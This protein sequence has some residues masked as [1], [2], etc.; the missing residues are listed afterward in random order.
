M[1]KQRMTVGGLSVG[2]IGAVAAGNALEFYDFLIF[3][4]F[5]VQIGN[6][7]FPLQNENSRL[8]FALATFGVGF[9]FR[10]VGG[11]LIGRMG[12][13]RG[14]K[15]AMLFS[16]GLMGFSIVGLALTP[17]YASIGVAAPVLAVI[18]RLIQGF[19]LGGEM[20]PSSAFL[21]EAAPPARRGLYVA[22]QFST[23]WVATLLAGIVGLVLTSHLTPDALTQWGWRVAFLIGALV[24]PFGLI[25]RRYLPET[26]ERQEE[27]KTAAPF[28]WGVVVRGLFMLA[29]G[30]IATYTLNY[31]VTFATHT[32]GL[33]SNVA[34]GATVICGLCGVVFT[35][36][37]GYLADRFGRKP[38]MLTTVTLLMLSVLPC[39]LAMVTIKTGPVLL[40]TAALM[41]IL[42]SLAMPPML[43]SLMENLPIATRS[44][45]I[46]TLYAIAI[47]VFGG[48]AQFAVAAMITVTGSP[49]MPAWYMSGALL[50]GLIA[51]TGMRETAPVKTGG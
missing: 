28:Q 14:R 3:S 40:G 43:V 37:G 1:E 11:F 19:A 26:L 39:F 6:V 29:A 27:A 38:M 50:L 2:Q 13:V 18:F 23:Q 15:P 45:G 9:L 8:L 44:G 35:L 12:D 21:M 10:P 49:L 47:S 20:G 51:M 16:F 30:T 7:F 17:S 5:A 41:A 46:G 48:T 22:M 31:L 25:V 24:V 42:L 36:V 33:P 32:L 4:F 34:F